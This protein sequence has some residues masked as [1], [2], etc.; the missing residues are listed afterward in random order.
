MNEHLLKVNDERFKELGI[1]KWQ[2]HFTGKGVKIGI[3]GVEEGSHHNGAWLINQVAPDAEVLEYHVHDGA[4]MN[5]TDGLRKC[6]EDD[7]DVIC[8]SLK[9]TSWNEERQSLSKQLYD[10]GVIMIDSSDNDNREI[11]R[12]PALDPH[13]FSVGVYDERTG[14]RAGYSNYGPNLDFVGYSN[15]FC[16]NK[17]DNYIPISHTSG[18]TQVP[19]GMVALL[20]ERNKNFGPKEFRKYIESL[21][22]KDNNIG[23]GLLRLPERTEMEIKGLIGSRQLIV[24]GKIVNMDTEAIIDSNKRTLVPLRAIGEAIGGKVT[25]DA[26]KKEFTIKL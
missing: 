1:R 21:G 10:I 12:Y 2:E 9:I 20:K 7:V 25:W 23:H 17:F 26:V 18:A 6:L 24:D 4:T 8:V 22:P 16:K 11:N 15:Y 3:L 19:S 5:F 13:W 14:T